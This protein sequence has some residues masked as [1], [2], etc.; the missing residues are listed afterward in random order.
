VKNI[1]ETLNLR[2]KFA[3]IVDLIKL[4]YLM[5]VVCHFSACAWHYLGTIEESYYNTSWISYYN[6]TEASRVSRYINSLYWSTITILTVGYGDMVPVII[7][8]LIF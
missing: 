8:N 7:Y 5:V 3:P 2:E 6:L 1:E 4:I